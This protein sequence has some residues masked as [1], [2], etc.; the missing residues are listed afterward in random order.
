M[1][2]FDKIDD[3]MIVDTFK[4]LLDALQHLRRLH[5]MSLWDCCHT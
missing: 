1:S 4:Q 3:N 5:Q 2:F